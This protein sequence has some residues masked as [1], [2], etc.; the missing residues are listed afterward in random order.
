MKL[1]VILLTGLIALQ[2]NL[3]AILDGR[4]SPIY[5]DNRY[6]F[7]NGEWARGT[8]FFNGGFDVPA[9]GTVYLSLDAGSVTNSIALNGGTIIMEKYLALQGRGYFAAPG[10]L[11]VKDLTKNA[12][13]YYE[14]ILQRLFLGSATSQK[15][16]VYGPFVFQALTLSSGFDQSNCTLDLS[17]SP[18]NLNIVGGTVWWRRVITGSG[19]PPSIFLYDVNMVTGSVTI[20]TPTVFFSG[21]S[22]LTSTGILSLQLLGIIGDG[23]L[24][25]YP[26]SRLKLTSLQIPNQARL[27]L[28][29]TSLDFTSTSTGQINICKPASTQGA[30]SFD[31]KCIIGSSTGNKLWLDQRVDLEFFAGAQLVINPGTFFSIIPLA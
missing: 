9:G 27:E 13:I 26:Q 4:I 14:C 24:T 2:G 3:W 12:F 29:N 6:T 7:T 31:G 1:H 18:S 5:L 23:K 20:N 11:R 16:K 21:L 10:Y 30:I 25:T 8:V 17:E 28:K 22:S 15:V 19:N